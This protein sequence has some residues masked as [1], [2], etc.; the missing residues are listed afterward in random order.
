MYIDDPSWSILDNQ[1]VDRV[2][3]IGQKKDVIIYRLITCATIEEK[4]YRKQVFKQGLMIATMED[5]APFRYFTKS[6]LH[7]M[8]TLDDPQS[9]V[10]Q[11]QLAVLHKGQRQASK[12]TESHIKNFV[13]KCS[14]VYGVSDHDLLFTRANAD[15]SAPID[16]LATVQ[17]VVE[18]ATQ[19]LEEVAN[20]PEA[21]RTPARSPA[22]KRRRKPNATPF[23]PAAR[24]SSSYGNSP[25][26][27]TSL[28]CEVHREAAEPIHISRCRCHCNEKDKQRY[29]LLLEQY[30]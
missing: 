2:Y 24:S 29:N 10:T 25:S 20:V 11:Q 30:E 8:F 17:Q 5:N 9:S 13:C 14:G 26:S 21:S 27:A 1:A 3:R 6:E 22:R 19:R 12:E 23:I 16:T 7:E 4:M 28:C 18:Q 15:G